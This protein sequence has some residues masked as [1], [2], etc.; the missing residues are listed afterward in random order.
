MDFFWTYLLKFWAFD[1]HV[2]S[3]RCSCSFKIFIDYVLPL[4][5]APFEMEWDYHHLIHIETW[6]KVFKNPTQKL[7]ALLT[8]DKVKFSQP[9]IL[10]NLWNFKTY[11]KAA[12]H[13]IRSYLFLMQVIC[14]TELP[15]LERPP[16]LVRP[17]E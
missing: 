15:R 5:L 17:P 1:V 13:D 2:K 11:P 9:I 16:R 8:K 6:F 14:D 4:L 3:A 10:P 7:T 12:L